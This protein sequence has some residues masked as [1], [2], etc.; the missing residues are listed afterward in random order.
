[1]N[2]WIRVGKSL[3]GESKTM[4]LTSFLRLAYRMADTAPILLP[5]KPILFQKIVSSLFIVEKWSTCLGLRI[6]TPCE[7]NQRCIECLCSHLIPRLH[8][9][10]PNDHILMKISM[11]RKRCWKITLQSQSKQRRCPSKALA[12]KIRSYLFYHRNFRDN[13][14][15]KHISLYTAEW[16]MLEWAGHVGVTGKGLSE[17]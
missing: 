13:I 7:Y 11:K 16:I 15:Y 2:S 17:R 3:K 4:H 12:L 14:W 8:N 9:L 6:A 10:L 1:M 5:H